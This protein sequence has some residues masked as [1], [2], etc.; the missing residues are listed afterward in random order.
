MPVMED[1]R[2]R[3][4][5]LL[6]E[7]QTLTQSASLSAEQR[8]RFTELDSEITQL[9]AELDLR[10]RQAE[11]EQ[12]AADARSEASGGTST[13]HTDGTAAP[14]ASG[15]SVGTEPTAYGRGSGHSYFMDLAR[16]SLRRGDGDGGV[17]AS[18]ERM[19]RHEAELRSE[20][21]R[22]AERRNAR[23]RRDFEEAHLSGSR[24]ER[25]AG[26]RAL[27]RM[28]RAGVTPFESRAMNRVDGTG[29]YLVPPLWLIDE[30]IPYLRAGRD[31]ANLWRGMEL[32]AGT[33]SINI[34]R[35]VIG[36]ATGPQVAD[37]ATVSG[38]DMQDAFVNA[39]VQTISGQ[40]DVALQLLEQSPIGGFD[41]MIFQDLAADYNLQLSGQCYVGSNT[42]GQIAG[43]WP[44]GVIS[45]ANGIY[46]PN[47]NNTA[48][49][50]WVN[51][52][53]A[54]FS[55]NNSVFQG[56][57]QM[58]SVIAR[59][60]LRAPTHHVW[61]PWVWYYL[62]TQVD[63]QGRPLV[64]PGTPNN[65]GF[66]QAGI[67]T[68]GPVSM[69]PVGW[70][71][72]LPV[73]LDPNMPVTFPASGGT[74]PQITTISAGQFAPTPGSG[75]FTPLLTGLWD[76]L[77]LWEGEMRTRALDQV[78]SGNLQMRFQL[79]NYVASMPNRYQAYANITTGT[80]PTTVAVT[81]SAMSYATLTQFSATAAN[82]VLNMTGQGF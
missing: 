26:A 15:W 58:L 76:D 73:I 30:L 22:R 25:R 80:G 19:N 32:P 62:L 17:H 29:G 33:D 48:S 31:F 36:S 55:V 7:M 69:G 81:G 78:L 12:R 49:Q 72:G 27:E 67:D 13:D 63:Q 9:D 56:G 8:A 23:A 74:N 16:I 21:P 2:S 24:A 1:L 82:S 43:I 75:V 45:N 51:G 59:T 57:G 42:A 39:K 41:E 79:Y 64:V 68:D 37:G 5:G 44:A 47:T 70:Y 34:P 40:M 53:G 46:I 11:R 3:R 66:N 54:T 20:M 77:F 60:R 28:D 14:G 6:D 61:H 52:G 65:V 4:Q 71:Q 50:T 10:D 18:Q 35:M 38:R